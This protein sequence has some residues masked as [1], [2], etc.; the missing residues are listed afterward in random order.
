LFSNLDDIWSLA[1][2]FGGIIHVKDAVQLGIDCENGLTRLN[3]LS[4]E[5]CHRFWFEDMVG[6]E[7][8]EGFGNRVPGLE[9]RDSVRFGL[10]LGILNHLDLNPMEVLAG[11]PVT[12]GIGSKA[13]H[14]D[15][16]FDACVT[17]SE[18]N[19]F[20]QRPAIQFDQRFGL[21]ARYGDKP[22]TVSGGEDQSSISG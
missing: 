13:C 1:P 4:E 19:V 7:Q 18:E 10:V 9:N 15:E 6:H 5:C 17:R 20:D 3:A 16:S 8:Q 22:A 11:R 14:D 12:Y 21:A 2:D